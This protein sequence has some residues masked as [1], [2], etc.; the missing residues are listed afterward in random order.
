MKSIRTLAAL[1]AITLVA[2][3]VTIN[4]YFPEAA[5]EE[6]A[7]RFIDDVIGPQEG[8]ADGSSESDERSAFS[9]NPLDWLFPAA[10]AQANIDI[11]TPAIRAIQSRME[12]RFS[13]ELSGYFASGAIGLTNDALVEIRDLSAIPLAQRNKVRA[14]V[15]AENEDRNAVYR[16]IAVANGHPE[17]EGQIRDIFADRWVAK[18]PSGWYFQSDGS[19]WKKK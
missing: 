7:D 11:N 12:Q 9:L 8:S 10:H 14:A 15:R 18:A 13:Q 5:A 2:A 3:C 6:A 16:E 19:G 17:W 4:V 1:G